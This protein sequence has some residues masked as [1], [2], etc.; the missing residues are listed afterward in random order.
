M[1]VHMVSV[2]ETEELEPM[3]IA[4]PDV[5]EA[6]LKVISHQQPTDSG[7]LDI[8]A[9]DEEGTIVVI[10]LKNE[11]HEGHLDQGLRYYDWC[12]QNISWIATAFSKDFT[13]NPES[14][15]RLMLVAP[16][17]TDTVKRIAK[18]VAAE[19]DLVEYRAFQNENGERGLICSRID[20]GSAPEPPE[21]PSLDKKIAHFTS[22]KAR[23]LFRT[24]IEQL[25]KRGVEVKPLN[26]LWSS[27]W[28]RGK[29]FGYIAPRKQYFIVDVLRPDGDWNNRQWISTKREWEATM[30]KSI[31]RYLQYLDGNK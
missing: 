8:L 2:R 25:R 26:G 11:A 19:L 6:G 18:Y 23:A 31:T 21:I 12:R 5:I 30:Q 29:R 4:H 9:V 24:A 20:F 28:Y 3:L 17:F 1:K 14:T 10:E 22:E 7:P 15:P 16:S 13:I 27:M